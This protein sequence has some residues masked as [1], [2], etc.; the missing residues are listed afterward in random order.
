MRVLL[1]SQ[2][3]DNILNEWIRRIMRVLLANQNRGNII[4]WIIT[5]VKLTYC[6]YNVIV[7][8]FNP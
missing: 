4:E 6:S 5:V 8:H 7:L 3:R 2:N 1:A